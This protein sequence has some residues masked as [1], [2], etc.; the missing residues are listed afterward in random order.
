[1]A[2]GG[3]NTDNQSWGFGWEEGRQTHSPPDWRKSLV[4]RTL[5]YHHAR[6][7]AGHDT[8][9]SGRHAEQSEARTVCCRQRDEDNAETTGRAKKVIP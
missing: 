1:M 3:L 9:D 6:R 2:A 8:E 4:S 5:R 7:V